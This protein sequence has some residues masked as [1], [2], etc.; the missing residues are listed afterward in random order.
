MVLSGSDNDTK[1]LATKLVLGFLHG[2]MLLGLD[3]KLVV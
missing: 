1:K 2:I 3:F